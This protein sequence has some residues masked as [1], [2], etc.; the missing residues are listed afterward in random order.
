MGL[1]VLSN[2]NTV[3][4]PIVVTVATFPLKKGEIKK[5]LVAGTTFSVPV[6]CI[7]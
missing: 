2:C 4:E 7:S 1:A 6:M 3:E 5:S